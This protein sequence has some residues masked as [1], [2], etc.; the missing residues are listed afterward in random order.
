MQHSVAEGNSNSNQSFSDRIYRPLIFIAATFYTNAWLDSNKC[1][2]K[3]KDEEKKQ[4]N[5]DSIL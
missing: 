5:N 3:K 2:I 4:K 1:L